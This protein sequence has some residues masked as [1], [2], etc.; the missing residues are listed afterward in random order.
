MHG[1]KWQLYSHIFHA[2]CFYVYF[3]TIYT[4]KNYHNTN[5]NLLTGIRCWK[6]M[7]I[8]AMLTL[9]KYRLLMSVV[10]TDYHFNIL[11]WIS[12]H[13]SMYHKTGQN[14]FQPNKR[15]QHSTLVGHWLLVSKD[16]GSNPMGGENFPSSF[17]SCDL[18]IS[19]YLGI[20]L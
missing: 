18:M 11:N 16:H 6:K 20:N 10:E 17:L 7:P 5:K 19:I 8:C 1:K 2:S 4:V 3:Y 14:L 13:S 9:G 15:G 12:F